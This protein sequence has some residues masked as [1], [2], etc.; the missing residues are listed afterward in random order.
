MDIWNLLEQR[1]PFTAELAE[2]GDINRRFGLTERNGFSGELRPVFLV[3]NLGIN[4]EI[5]I[6]GMK[7]GLNSAG[8]AAF[9]EEK[10]AIN[11]DFA[12]YKSS[13][14]HYFDSSALNRRHY[15]PAAKA[16]ATLL[17]QPFP[18]DPG[19]FL[20]QNAVQVELV[21]FFQPQ[22]VL[23]DADLAR[24]RGEST[25]GQL[26]SEVL[27]AVLAQ[28][29]WRAIIVRYAQ[30]F[31]VFKTLYPVNESASGYELPVG[32]RQIPVF[33]LAG[34][35]IS[36]SQVLA[37]TGER[38]AP[39][40]AQRSRTR[41]IN[42][43]A[44]IDEAMNELRTHIHALGSDVTPLPQ[45]ANGS[46]VFRRRRNFVTLVPARSSLRIDVFT[47]SGWR[48]GVSVLPGVGIAEAKQL[49]EEA[50]ALAS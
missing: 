3:G 49:M 21:P 20:S 34:R 22:A 23:S 19:R 30:T 11:Q 29:N 5:L 16:V 10:R 2:V 14:T 4:P 31:R 32:D 43:E 13:R 9:D 12:R 25:G 48:D 42:A 50:Y 41:S 39:R 27:D 24:V 26:A 44:D 46:F 37:L 45:R 35:Y 36:D 15:W 40:I 6:I 33:E 18:E 28:G 17:G 7:P 8:N 47:Q 38:P 1:W